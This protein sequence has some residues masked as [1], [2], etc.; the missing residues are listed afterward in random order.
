MSYLLAYLLLG[1]LVGLA[2]ALAFDDRDSPLLWALASG[3][4]WPLT[5]LLVLAALAFDLLDYLLGE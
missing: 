1:V 2:H 4:L 5:A 3:L